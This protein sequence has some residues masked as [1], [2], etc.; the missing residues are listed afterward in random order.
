VLQVLHGK[1]RSRLLVRLG[2]DDQLVE[3]FKPVE[4]PAWMG[5]G[6]WSRLLES[7]KVRGVRRT[8]Y[9]EGLT[10]LLVQAVRGAWLGARRRTGV[11]RQRLA[12]DFRFRGVSGCTASRGQVIPSPGLSLL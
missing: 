7:I 6:Q 12:E 8:V 3:Y 1:P 4:K 10:R 11:L 9:R 2:T 5:E